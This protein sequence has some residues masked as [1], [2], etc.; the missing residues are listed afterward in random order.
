MGLVPGQN[1]RLESPIGFPLL[2]ILFLIALG[3]FKKLIDVD[4]S[5]FGIDTTVAGVSLQ[6][7]GTGM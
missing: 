3:V 1:R 5:Q 2:M 7:V 6:Q 4:V